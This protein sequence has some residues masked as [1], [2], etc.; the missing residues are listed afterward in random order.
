[1]CPGLRK[2]ILPKKPSSPDQTIKFKR[3][4]FKNKRRYDL[5]PGTQTTSS[6]HRTSS[7]FIP[8]RIHRA[9]RRYAG[10]F[11]PI[12]FNPALAV[13]SVCVQSNGRASNQAALRTTPWHANTLAAHTVHP[14]FPS[15]VGY[16][17]LLGVAPELS[18]LLFHPALF[19]LPCLRTAATASFS[20]ASAF[21]FSLVPVAAHLRRVLWVSAMCL[22]ARS[23]LLLP[24]G[25]VFF[26]LFKSYGVPP[27]R[28]AAESLHTH[29]MQRNVPTAE[30]YLDDWGDQR[31]RY[32]FTGLCLCGTYMG[33]AAVLLCVLRVE[34]TRTC[35]NLPYYLTFLQRSCG[36][37]I[38]YHI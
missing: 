22:F 12:L 34:D 5:H 15:L 16:T 4:R 26:A 6:A 10:T 11:A 28:A 30:R 35:S 3:L 29:T 13:C 25:C 9:L 20:S 17:A 38:F 32:T 23:R 2:K 14:Q 19:G 31:S 18:P 8:R 24:C 7:F 37:N 21:I 36:T 33:S 1:M 27:P